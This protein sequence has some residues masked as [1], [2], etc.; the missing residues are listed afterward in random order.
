M[1]IAEVYGKDKI[2][3]LVSKLENEKSHFAGY[4]VIEIGNAL[5]EPSGVLFIALGEK[6]WDAIRKTLHIFTRLFSMMYLMK[7]IL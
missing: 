2:K 4:D 3:I 6:H 7:M 5:I 1:P